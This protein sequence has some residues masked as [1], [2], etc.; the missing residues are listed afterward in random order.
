MGLSPHPMFFHEKKVESRGFDQEDSQKI[1]THRSFRE[2]KTHLAPPRLT[3]FVT[4]IKKHFSSEIAD[5][6]LR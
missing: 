4:G 6:A 5:F 3:C 2:F 1:S